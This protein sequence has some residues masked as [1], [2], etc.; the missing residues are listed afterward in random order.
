MSKES[1]FEHQ[2]AQITLSQQDMARAI[3]YWLNEK[4]VKIPIIVIGMS[5]SKLNYNG[6]FTIKFKEARDMESTDS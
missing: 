2:E 5:E 1:V 3:E 6:T 4:V